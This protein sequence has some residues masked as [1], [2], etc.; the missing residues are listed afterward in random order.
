MPKELNLPVF[1]DIKVST[2]TF[3]ANTNITID[4]HKLFDLIEIT[5]Y[6]VL[7][8]K[9]GRKRKGEIKEVNQNIPHGSII[10]VKCEGRIK[11]VELKPKKPKINKDGS[12]KKTWFRNSVTIV[13]M[14]DKLINFKVCRNGTFQMTGC[15]EYTHPSE[16]IKHIW[17]IMK[18]DTSIYSFTRNE[19]Q[20]EAL[21]IPSMRNI[22]FDLGFNV[23]RDKLSTCMNK[24][25]SLHCLLETSFGY[26]GVNIKIPQ[27]KSK[28]ELS[29]NK[30][31]CSGE[32]WECLT[33]SYQEYMDVLDEKTRKKKMNEKRFNTFLVFHSGKVIFSGITADFMK[34]TYYSFT[35]ILE[36]RFD[37]IEE[38]LEK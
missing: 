23:D 8:K 2:K 22:D 29:V 24:E 27:T 3:T 30:L 1:E 12:V 32:K 7:P 28:D 18:H 17:G 4:I 11:G 19:H 34:D 33:S 5:P 20:F 21:L 37:E 25:T 15:T 6:T 16:C 9:R 38:R 35:K 10:S 26:T 14:F 13:V 36:N 31:V